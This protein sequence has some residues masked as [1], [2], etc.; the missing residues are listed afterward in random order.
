MRGGG[1]CISHGGKAKQVRAAESLALG[2]A[3]DRATRTSKTAL[4]ASVQAQI[5][6]IAQQQATFWL[7][8]M[9][10]ML[11]DPRVVVNGD[12]EDVLFETL[13]AVRDE[14][15]GDARPAL[16]SSNASSHGP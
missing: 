16:V 12:R 10:R 1:V 3:I 4:D 5:A 9:R 6:G 2:W 7:A 15:V 13:Q 11:A 8:A 14:S